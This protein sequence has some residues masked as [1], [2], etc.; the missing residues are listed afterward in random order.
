MTTPST[1]SAPIKLPLKSIALAV[2]GGGAFYLA[3]LAYSDFDAVRAAFAT[4]AWSTYLILVVIS[5]MS[6]GARFIRWHLFLK[7]LDAKVR[8]NDSALIYFAGFALTMTPAKA[9]E[10]I[11][12]LYLKSKG[13]P[14]STTLGAFV[15]ERLLDVLAVGALSTLLFLAL[16]DYQ[17]VVWIGAGGVLLILL[18]LRLGLVNWVL[19]LLPAKKAVLHLRDFHDV[20]RDL[21]VGRS[22]FWAFPLSLFAWFCQGVSLWLIVTTLGVDL[23]LWVV[24]GVYCLSILVGA[25]SFIPGGLGTTEASIVILLGL[26][27]VDTSVAVAA[28]ILCR[29]MTLW[30]AVSIGVL[31][32]ARLARNKGEY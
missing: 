17:H 19:G 26:L 25:A 30:F 10:T 22:L 6:Y 1:P 31:S 4:L 18:G 23:S 13:V 3:L 20:V 32:M 27:G 5:L 12:S 21:L 8:L 28:A 29:V 7:V 24:V 2:G 11:R 16:N 14:Y 15:S 9:G